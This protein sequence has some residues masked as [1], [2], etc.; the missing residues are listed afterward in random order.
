MFSRFAAV[1]TAVHPSIQEHG[2][3]VDETYYA[4]CKAEY[5]LFKSAELEAD[6]LHHFIKTS[7]KGKIGKMKRAA[8]FFLPEK[9]AH[10]TPNTS[11]TWASLICHER[12]IPV[13]PTL[14]TSDFLTALTEL[15][16]T[17]HAI[18]DCAGG[19]KHATNNQSNTSRC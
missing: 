10:V 9:N 2:V 16:E 15:R 3:Y 19:P 11:K 8:T 1:F 12:I 5:Q 13:L 6:V 14:D 17:P 4:A 18:L 7:Q